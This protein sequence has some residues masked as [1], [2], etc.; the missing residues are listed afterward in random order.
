MKEWVWPEQ[1]SPELNSPAAPSLPCWA[2]ICSPKYKPSP[3]ALC[4]CFSVG[5]SRN[6]A[7]EMRYFIPALPSVWETPLNLVNLIGIVIP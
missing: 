4:T 1:F 2:S 5:A 3:H 6:A 7:E